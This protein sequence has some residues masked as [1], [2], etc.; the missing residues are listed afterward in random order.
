[1][2]LNALG[3]QVGCVETARP[4][5]QFYGNEVHTPRG[6]SGVKVLSRSLFQH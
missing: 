2:T 4:A 3:D 6:T 1:M 5:D